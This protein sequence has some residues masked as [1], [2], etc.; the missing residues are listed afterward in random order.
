[1]AN[2]VVPGLIDTVRTGS[3]TTGGQPALHGTHTTLLG[4]RGQP[5]EIAAAVG[6]L[7][8]PQ[9]RYVTGQ[10][11]HVNGGAFLA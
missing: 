11:L 5:E 1:M 7:C 8:G 10:T 6:F 9:A 2:C 3:S 4:R